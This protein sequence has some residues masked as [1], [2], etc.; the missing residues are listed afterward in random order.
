MKIDA[1]FI[2]NVINNERDTKIL[3]AILDIAKAIK[4][5]V[6]AEGVETQEHLHYLRKIGC[7]FAQGPAISRPMPAEH[8]SDWYRSWTNKKMP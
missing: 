6:I 3:K 5:K 4:I 2:L 8:F 1:E 7:E